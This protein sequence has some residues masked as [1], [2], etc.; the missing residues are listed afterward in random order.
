MRASPVATKNVQEEDD[1]LLKNEFFR[2]SQGKV[3]TVYRS[4][5][6]IYNLLVLHFLGILRSTLLKSVGFYWV[7]KKEK[8][9]HFW[10]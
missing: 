6:Q 3:A 9:G 1:L 10:E 4:H 7:I 2:I 5:G 8:G